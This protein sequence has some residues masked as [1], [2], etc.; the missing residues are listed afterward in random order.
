MT[1]AQPSS[2]RSAAPPLGTAP[3]TLAAIPPAPRP[4]KLVI[5]IPCLNEEESLPETLAAMPRVIDGVDVVEIQIINDGST[6]RTVE[7]ARA[8]GADHIVD[9]PVNKG[10][11]HA[12]MAGLEHALAKGADIIVNIDADNQYNADDIPALITPILERRAEF[13][14]G[15][16][17]ISTIAHFSRSKRLLQLLGSAVVRMAS[18]TQ[19]RDAPSGFRAISRD[20]ALRLNS[21][22]SYTYTLETI[23][24]SGLSGIR[25]VSVPIGVNGE[26]RPS[27]LIRSI[28]QYIW[29]SSRS[30]LRTALVYAPG[31]FLFRL[32]LPLLVAGLIL[33]ARWLWLTIDGSPRAHVPSLLAAAG[34]LLTT[35]MLWVA[36]I[37]GE[38]MAIN[39]RL[40]QDIQYRLRKD[41]LPPPAEPD[42]GT[43]AKQ[44]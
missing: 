5:Q 34:L 40:L 10:L 1:M 41:A 44:P 31:K 9:L 4:I 12:F 3:A 19:V 37:T 8:N 23:V 39:R 32:S 11:S 13:V 20:A 16:R 29:R 22:D 36:A 25:I 6:D 42:D 28:P 30:I 38:Q 24:Q 43:D 15:D 7:V 21:F 14:V 33:I 27:R 17:P 2:R 18:E 35:V 26:T